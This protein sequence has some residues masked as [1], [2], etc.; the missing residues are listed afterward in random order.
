[1]NPKRRPLMAG[2][3]KMNAGGREGCDLAAAVAKAAKECTHSDVLVAPPFPTLAAV[4]HVLAELKSRVGIASQTVHE[5]RSG[6]FTGEVSAAMVREAGA[7]WAIVGHSERRHGLGESHELVAQ[8]AKAALDEGLSPII[9]IGETLAERDAGQLEAVLVAQLDPVM[10]LIRESNGRAV[11]AYEP[12]WAI[13]TGKV[14]TPEDAQAAHAFVR[15]KIAS[16][17]PEAAALTRILYG[18]SMKPDNVEGLL[19][20]EDIDGGLVGGA[21]LDG[22]SFGKLILASEAM[23]RKLS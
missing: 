1:M 11:I 20:Q 21:S 4:A 12:V 15:K 22:A 13:G 5:A 3:W 7:T 8:K 9:C 19:A 16:A 2:N 23:A 10:D 6:A 18:G 14:A 17:S